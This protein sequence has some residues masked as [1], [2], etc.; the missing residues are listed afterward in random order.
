MSGNRQN[1]AALESLK[2]NQGLYKDDRTGFDVDVEDL[3]EDPSS[4]GVY[5]LPSHIDRLDF[6]DMKQDAL[7]EKYNHYFR[8]EEVTTQKQPSGLVLTEY[9]FLSN[10]IQ[11]IR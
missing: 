8:N 3:V 9:I 6:D 10:F 2:E 5:T 11:T 7:K 4:P 1:S